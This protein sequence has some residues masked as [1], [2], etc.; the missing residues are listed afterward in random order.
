MNFSSADFVTVNEIL[1]DVLK[2]VK[3]EDYRLNSKGWY[4]SQVQQALE[5]LSFDTFFSKGPPIIIPISDGLKIPIP[6]GTFNIRQLYITNGNACNVGHSQVVWYKRN[7][8]AGTESGYIAR[9]KYN[10]RD[11][12]YKNRRSGNSRFAVGD[13]FRNEPTNL[14]YYGVH[15]GEINLSANCRQFKNLFIVANR[16]ST[17]VGDVPLVPVYLRQAVKSF[18]LIEAMEVK[19]ADEI[20]TAAFNQWATLLNKQVNDKDNMNN[21]TW[22]TAERRV[23]M[24]DSKQRE[25]LN[26]YFSRLDY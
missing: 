13:D 24:L 12:F 10:N 21:G 6:K 5:E 14:Y 22:I 19:M 7:F 20:G 1:S 3:D 11:P 26:E 9:D 2:L 23:K 18:V 4:T 17:E 25:D 16:I 15:D 8:I